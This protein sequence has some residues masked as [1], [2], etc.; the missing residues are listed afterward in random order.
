MAEIRMEYWPIE[1]LVHYARNPRENDHA[2]EQ[3]V[4][5]IK[6]FGFRIPVAALST[7]EVVD[8]HLRLKAG[9]R[10]GMKMIPVIPADDMTPAQIKAFRL[11]ANRSATWANWDDDLLKL[12]FLDLR[13]MD[14]D[15]SLTGFDQDEIDDLFFDDADAIETDK[16]PDHVPELRDETVTQPGDIWILGEH[17]LMC[18]DSADVPSVLALLGGAKAGCCVTSPPYAMQRKDS[19]G[20]VPVDEYPAWFA[21]IAS[22]VA[23]VLADGGSFFVNIKEHVEDGERSLYVFETIKALRADG[24]RYVDQMLWVKPGLPGTWPNRLRNDFEPVH[25][26]SKHEGVDWMVQFVDVDTEKLNEAMDLGTVSMSE[27]IVH[28]TRQKKIK[29]KPRAVGKKSSLIREP[30]SKNKSGSVNGNIGV[31]AKYKTGIARPANVLQVGQNWENLGHSAMFPV[32][33]PTFFIKLTTD[34][35]DVVYEPFSGSGTTLIAADQAGRRCCAMERLPKY[36]DL[37]V[38]R[39]QDVTGGTA[40]LEAT[41][42]AFSEDKG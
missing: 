15:L 18:G 37:A 31:S 42:A 35:G 6:E 33:L 2:V 13:E 27:D 14:Y 39:W 36:V 4:G 16:D 5:A 20:G 34:V 19:Y 12:E 7:G 8:G 41:G 9:Q 22:A 32:S 17:R 29:F 1:R 24:W 30:S 38:R 25:F 28:F 23:A 11:I 26:F 21:K 3:M 40:V 10:L